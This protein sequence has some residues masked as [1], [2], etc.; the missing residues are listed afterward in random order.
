[1]GRSLPAAEV[2]A[3]INEMDALVEAFLNDMNVPVDLLRAMKGIR[4]EDIQVLSAQ[5]LQRLMLNSPDPVW[6]ELDV[7]RQAW[8]YGSS[9]GDFRHRRSVAE[10]RCF[11]ERAPQDVGVIECAEAIYY[12]IQLEEYRARSSNAE[13]ICWS[14]LRD[15]TTP[16][17]Q[18]ENQEAWACIRD[19]MI[20]VRP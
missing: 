3:R 6:D 10:S 1:M 14:T 12:G 16:T 11:G 19:V 9:S 17:S 8:E 20:G 2:R 13:L 15:R 18:S 7:A 4:A 5:D